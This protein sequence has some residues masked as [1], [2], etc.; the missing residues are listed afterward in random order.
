MVSLTTILIGILALGAI[1]PSLADREPWHVS[2]TR[3]RNDSSP[4]GSVSLRE[5]GCE[6]MRVGRELLA[7]GYQAN[8]GCKTFQ[9]RHHPDPPFDYFIYRYQRYES[10]EKW[11]DDPT[12]S[13]FD[14]ARMGKCVL[15]AFSL[16]DCEGEILAEVTDAQKEEISDCIPVRSPGAVSVL[17]DCYGV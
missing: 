7:A 5:N 16:P 9:R 10:F 12:W 8:K 1:S 17:L 15:R 3:Y 4:L 13:N 11:S 6:S 2:F 14:P